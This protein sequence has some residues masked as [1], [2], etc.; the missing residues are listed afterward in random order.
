MRSVA[1]SE[2]QKPRA[3]ARSESGGEQ[4]SEEC[5]EERGAAAASSSEEQDVCTYIYIM[6]M[7]SGVVQ[8]LV[9][10]KRGGRAKTLVC[11]SSLLLRWVSFSAAIVVLTIFAALKDGPGFAWARRNSAA[12]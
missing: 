12:G 8:G 10:Q 1:R 4:S 6:C 9:S 2:E 5:S 3:A 7:Y 11:V